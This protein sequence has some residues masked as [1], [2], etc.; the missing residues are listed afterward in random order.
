MVKTQKSN[1]KSHLASPVK[2]NKL[3]VGSK[4][5]DRVNKQRGIIREA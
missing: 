2:K 1:P 3:V 5:K 4:A